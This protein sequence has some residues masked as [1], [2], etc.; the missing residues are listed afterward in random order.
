MQFY[1]KRHLSYRAIQ[2]DEVTPPDAFDQL[3]KIKMYLRLRSEGC[4][5]ATALDAIGWS[6]ATL[7]SW[8]AGRNATRMAESARSP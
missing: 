4:S 5:E 6:R 2:V 8:T 1:S 3:R 7:H